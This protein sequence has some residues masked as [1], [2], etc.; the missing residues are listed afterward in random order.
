MK[1]LRFN[2]KAVQIGTHKLKSEPAPEQKVFESQ[3]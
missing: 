1:N 3:S 2:L